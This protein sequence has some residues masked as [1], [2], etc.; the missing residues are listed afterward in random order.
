MCMYNNAM[1][2]GFVFEK[3]ASSAV[4]CGAVIV[5]H[6]LRVMV[7]VDERMHYGT[8][9][10]LLSGSALSYSDGHANA[11]LR[12]LRSPGEFHLNMRIV[13]EPSVRVL[14]KHIH[15]SAVSQ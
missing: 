4:C 9:L 8:H 7:D 1:N 6:T 14:G 11:S 15:K 12:R 13:A 10:R 3:N 5:R 2:T